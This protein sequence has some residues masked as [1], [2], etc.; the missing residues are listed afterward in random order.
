MVQLKFIMVI[1]S[2]TC[3]IEKR[4][5]TDQKALFVWYFSLKECFKVSCVHIYIDWTDCWQ[6]NVASSKQHSFFPCRKNVNRN[7]HFSS[8]WLDFKSSTISQILAVIHKYCQ[9]VQVYETNELKIHLMSTL[10]QIKNLVTSLKL[11]YGRL[12]A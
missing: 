11:F 3:L 1:P 2:L 8:F 4:F 5:V 6:K 7:L 12:W 9:W 10:I